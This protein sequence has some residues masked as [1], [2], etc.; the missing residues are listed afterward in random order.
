MLNTTDVMALY[1]EGISISKDTPEGV[2]II[3]VEN[4]TG[5][6]DAGLQKGDIITKISGNEVTNSA[7]LRY[8]L[9]KHKPGD[10]VEVTYIRDGK[11]KTVKVKL[12]KLKNE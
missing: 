9:Y 5:A 8:E 11:E 12:S 6:K 4:G 2:V 3:S 1:R 7:Y 10:T